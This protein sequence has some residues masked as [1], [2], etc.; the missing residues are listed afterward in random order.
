MQCCHAA[1]ASQFANGTFYKTYRTTYCPIQYLR[2]HFSMR[3]KCYNHSS[4]SPT[5]D[6]PSQS[7]SCA[8]CA[9]ALFSYYFF[10]P[11]RYIRKWNVISLSLSLFLPRSTRVTAG[12]RPPPSTQVG[13]FRKVKSLPKCFTPSVLEVFFVRIRIYFGSDL[14]FCSNFKFPDLHH[15][16][17]QRGRR[18]PSSIRGTRRRN[19]GGGG[20]KEGDCDETSKSIW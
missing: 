8:K 3:A 1:R 4:S 6:D 7:S 15:Q 10:D 20:G 19:G 13:C 12:N 9:V 2:F 5:C 18:R 16:K 17:I 14:N 11:A